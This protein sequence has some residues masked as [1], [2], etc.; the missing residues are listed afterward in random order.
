MTT[1][2]TTMLRRLVRSTLATAAALT[3]AAATACT[4]SAPQT[5]ISFST[6]SITIPAEAASTPV[7]YTTNNAGDGQ[8]TVQCSEWWLTAEATAPGI[9]M[10]TA[11]A[12]DSE[13]ERQATLTASAGESTATLTVIQQAGG[14]GFFTITVTETGTT[15]IKADI[16]PQDPQTTYFV[17]TSPKEFID[18]LGTDEAIFGAIIDHYTSYAQ[19]QG[20]TLEQLLTESGIL[21]SGSSSVTMDLLPPDTDQYIIAAGST[22]TGERTTDVSLK[23]FRTAKVEMV[24][25]SFTISYDIQGPDVTMTVVPDDNTRYYYFDVIETAQLEASGKTPAEILQEYINQDLQLGSAVGIS[26][27]EMLRE[28][29]SKGKDSYFYNNLTAETGHT[30]CACGVSETGS[31]NSEVTTKTFTTGAV[32]ASDNKITLTV[33]SANLDRITARVQTTNTDPYVLLAVEESAMEGLDDSQIISSLLSNDLSP[34]TCSG[35]TEKTIGGLKPDTRYLVLAFGYRSG[36][37]TTALTKVQAST[38][39]ESDPAALTFEFRTWDVGQ[40]TVYVSV[41]GT[42]ASALYFW[43]ICPASWT[44]DDIQ[45]YLDERIQ[46]CI[47]KH[48]VKDAADFY[49]QYG[50]RGLNNYG[51][52][53]RLESNTEY[54]VY[55]FGVYE[56]T[57]ERA[58]AIQYSETFRTLP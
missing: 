37:A 32:E 35:D 10:I 30:G 41:E 50:S 23:A 53:I 51:L 56:D 43:E 52:Y 48:Y 8:V 26:P 42:P 14:T 45:D 33:T 13:D 25:M 15:W 49:R 55:A 3:A 1:D 29:C 18:G 27:E 31:V 5:T 47:D 17:M 21:Y 57:G 2:T 40:N 6:D 38:L 16:V 12:N 44:E 39:S 7:G 9:I 28:I 58:T 11:E 24:P 34:Y 20:K 4:E 36:Q 46:S 19:G 22:V 54:V